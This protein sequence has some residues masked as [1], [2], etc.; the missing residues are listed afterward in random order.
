MIPSIPVMMTYDFPGVQIM[1]YRLPAGFYFSTFKDDE[2][3]QWARLQATTDSF[4]SIAEA[5][6]Y[7]DESFGHQ[8]L[9]LRDRCYFLHADTEKYIG[10]AMAWLAEEPFDDQYGRLHWV[11]VHPKY[12]GRGLGKAL[13]KYTMRKLMDYY[14][15][16][17]LTSQTNS[18]KALNIYLEI[19]F[20][21]RVL[22][23]KDRKAWELVKKLLDNRG[24]EEDI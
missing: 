15:R 4:M 8:K 12:Q 9:L 10:S 19:G 24:K 13:V 16:G 20:R 14:T 17:Y 2:A 11:A 3:D 7:F 6:S 21:P 23:D 1:D 18:F 22:N 5:R